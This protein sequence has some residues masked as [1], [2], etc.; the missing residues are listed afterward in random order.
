MAAVRPYSM[1]PNLPSERDFDP[2]GGDLD[3]QCA[4]RNFG[5]LTLE[6]AIRRFRERPELYQEDF[7]HMGGRAFDYYYPVIDRFL[8]DT[9]S[10]SGDEIDDR[11][12]WILPQCIRNQFE[13]KNLPYVRNRKREVLELCEFMLSNLKVFARDWD[14]PSEIESQWTQLRSHLQNLC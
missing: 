11:Q 3:A 14:P 12:S 7:M 13:G 8:R 4:W 1:N 9:L 10:L 2:Y 5:G 6:E